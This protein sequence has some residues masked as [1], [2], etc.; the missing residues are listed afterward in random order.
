ANT[1]ILQG[2]N[3]HVITG[4]ASGSLQ[5]E[6]CELEMLDDITHL[7]YEGALDPAVQG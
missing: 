1:T 2:F 7:R 3:A 5:K 6:F 4:G